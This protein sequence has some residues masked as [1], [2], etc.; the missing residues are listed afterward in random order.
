MVPS[1]LRGEG[2]FLL[3]NCVTPNNINLFN[4]NLLAKQVFITIKAHITSF[5]IRQ[6]KRYRVGT[7]LFR[8]FMSDT[9]VVGIEIEVGTLS[10]IVTGHTNLANLAIITTGAWCG[11]W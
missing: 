3:F 2:A 5:S 9:F 7:E 10:F 4:I 8:C 6:L 11:R 1:P